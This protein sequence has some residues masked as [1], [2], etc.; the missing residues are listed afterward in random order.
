MKLCNLISF[1]CHSIH[2]LVN[3]HYVTQCNFILSVTVWTTWERCVQA[4]G[5]CWQLLGSGAT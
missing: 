5:N 1:V 4:R 2:C 3:L